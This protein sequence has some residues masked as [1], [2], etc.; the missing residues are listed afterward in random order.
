MSEPER[1]PFGTVATERPPSADGP[2]PV[3]VLGAYPSALHVRWIPP[4]SSQLRSVKALPVADEPTPF[5]NGGNAR[6]RVAAWIAERGFDP[7]THGT[8]AP[9]PRFNGTSGQW[10]D[11]NVLAPLDCTRATTWITDCLDTY[12]LSNGARKG[13]AGTYDAARHRYG[14]PA[15]NL[16][17]HPSEDEVVRESWS[18]H[19]ER[20]R[21]ELAVCEPEL[22][23]SLGNAALAVMGKLLSAGPDRLEV[24]GYGRRLNGGLGGR[25]VEWLPLAHPAAPQRYQEAHREWMADAASAP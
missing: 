10:V 2:R 3:F 23:V 13:L 18:W 7:A 4:A 1:Y 9:A 14:W 8:F 11:V 15:W 17:G 21:A 5:W 16:R 6:E 20:L 22:V 19:K 25:A 24:D 12:R